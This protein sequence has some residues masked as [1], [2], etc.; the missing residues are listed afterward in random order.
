MNTTVEFNQK[1]RGHYKVGVV[2]PAT[3]DVEWKCS[4]SNLIINTGMDALY[5]YSVA[6]CM[7]Y[8]ISGTGQRPN[9]K[10]SGLSQISQSGNTVYLSNAGGDITDFTSSF[11]F[12]PA[13]VEAG[14]MISCS[15]GQQLYVTAVNPN[16]VNLTVTPS[17]TFAAQGFAVYKTSQIGLQIEIARTSNYLQGTGNCGSTYNG[18]KIVHRRTYDFAARGTDVSYNELGTGWASSGAYNVFSRILINPVVVYAGFVLRFVYDLEVEYGPTSSL[19]GL[20]SIGGWT[21]TMGTQSVQNFLASYVQTTGASYNNYAP[22]DPYY[23]TV[24]S[25]Y[26][27]VWVSS[28][29]TPLAA[30]GSAVNRSAT[31]AVSSVAM[32]KAAYTNGNY[33]CDRTGITPSGY[34]LNV[35]SLGFGTS[36]GGANASNSTNQA[37]CFVFDNAQTLLNTQTVSLTFRHSWTRILG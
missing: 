6:D 24:G 11:D 18:N 37:F 32:S 28:N 29:S 15:N 27:S 34:S 14:D 4:G 17:Y 9:N 1:L 7:T 12:Y 21:N 30:F 19:Y 33:Y 16:G 20:A 25:Q 26:A 2:D 13:L 23:T 22:L 36:G 35:R 31:A 10:D 3:N 5:T 8:G